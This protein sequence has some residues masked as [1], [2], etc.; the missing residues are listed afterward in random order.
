VASATSARSHETPAAAGAQS[1][2]QP[3]ADV[4]A[5][6]TH[7]DFLLELGQALGGQ[8]AVRPVDT[9][10]A[11]LECLT[12]SRRGQV[13][14]IDSRDVTDVR[15]AVDTSQ[16]AAPR[17]V[18]LVFAEGTAEKQLGTALKGSRV[19]AVL[20]TPIDPRKTQAVLDAAI[21]DAVAAKA[22]ASASSATSATP[23]APAASSTPG[24]PAAPAAAG[25]AGPGAPV[26]AAIA[27]QLSELSIGTFRP[28]T[29][30]ARSGPKD[31]GM[32]GMGLIATAAV[33]VALAGGAYWFLGHRGSSPAPA[34]VP[35]AAAPSTPAESRTPGAA[36]APTATAATDGAA[37][38]AAA[39][40]TA[41]VITAPTADT[42]I[43]KGKVDE[44]LEK[45]RLAMHERRF[46]EP[47]ADN[48]L[49]YYRSA[50]AADGTN[51]EARD[52]LQRV[53]GVLAG[54]F[55]EAMSGARLEDAALTLANF[56]TATPADPRLA[57][58]EQR[59]Y[60]AEISKALAD[61]NLD[62]AAV[63]LHQAQQTGQ[64]PAEQIVR[65]RADIVRHQEDAKAQ[66][67]AGLVQD[68]IRDG[69]L[70][71][72]DDSAKAYLQ[73]L[74]AASPA[75][76]GTQRAAHD[77]ASAYLR[78]AREAALA[79][80]NADVE[81]WLGEARAA[82]VRSAEIAAFQRD[83]AG[84]RQK[85]AQAEGERLT[86][87]AR[88]RVRDGRLTDP[89]QD[90]AAYYLTQ[91][92]SS[93]PTSASFAEVSHELAAK[94]LDRARTA[95]LAGRPG[96]ADLAQARRWGADPKDVL[97]VQQMQSAP[98]KGAA[99]DV[100]ALAA[101][102]KRVRATMPDYPASALAQHLTGSVMLEYTVDTRG[103]TR[104]IHVVEATPP[105]VFDE[106]AISAV[107]HW[108]YAPMVVNGAPVEVP[109]RT[110]VR[111]ELPK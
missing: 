15:A 76:A 18:V 34:V 37:A 72:G 46:T 67:L 19:F 29:A 7:D 105:G 42:L 54:R 100:A 49:V 36:T 12:S 89:A 64:I 73:Q 16:A 84:A 90:S 61:G 82:G 44:L 75:S 63:Y 11:A 45:A 24:A 25:P 27:A 81:R 17:A 39:A 35:A 74:Q 109:V 4:V 80:N 99:L 6:T 96:D 71:D 26:A 85:A 101:N 97:A 51:A 1:A 33:A 58:F 52:G 41:P 77:L 65:W 5:L 28:R 3:S 104:D 78:K 59:L 66:R 30:P 79:K 60:G 40:D 93:D 22:A 50:I 62:R 110:R 9:V 107:K 47:T 102:L 103:G 68:R 57:A 94:L 106:A 88:D 8:A 92:Q 87:M 53:A 38:P 13:L 20:P 98:K 10:D 31:T 108:R 86:Q 91:L 48:A 111:F 21:A 43:V 23:A 14:V 95:V 69:R 2:S 70:T 83:L 32:P 56:K 55:E